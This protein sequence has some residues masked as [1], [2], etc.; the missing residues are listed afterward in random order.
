[1]VNF[2]ISID[3]NESRKLQL[4][5]YLENILKEQEDIYL[6]INSRLSAIKSF[7]E[8]K[9]NDLY[10]VAENTIEQINLISVDLINSINQT[11]LECLDSFKSRCNYDALSI[12]F[13][14]HVAKF[15][16]KW[17]DYLEKTNDDDNQLVSAN[18]LAQDLQGSLI[19]IKDNLKQDLLDDKSTGRVQEIEKLIKSKYGLDSDISFDKMKKID[20]SKHFA[21][22]FLLAFDFMHDENSIL[23]VFLTSETDQDKCI[24]FLQ[25]QKFGNLIVKN[26]T[27]RTSLT[28][29]PPHVQLITCQKRFVFTYF[30]EQYQY[31][32][33][34]N[35]EMIE[36]ASDKL[37][38]NE[39]IAKQL[40]KLRI[41]DANETKIYLLDHLDNKIKVYDWNLKVISFNNFVPDGIRSTSITQLFVRENRLFL[42]ENSHTNKI[43]ILDANEFNLIYC[44]PISTFDLSKEIFLSNCSIIVKANE[45]RKLIFYDF[46]LSY[47]YER[48]FNL[49]PSEKSDQ[50]DEG[51]FSKL[52]FRFN[53]LNE[54][55]ICLDDNKILYTLFQ[56]YNFQDF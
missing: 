48:C 5:T 35:E 53:K 26:S 3:N 9:R 46:N 24:L 41:C 15:Y 27:H 21:G 10:T 18:Q 31:I 52:L 23:F 1:L 14:D 38:R 51:L 17:I 20:L 22:R 12:Y 13:K 4:K 56:P 50:V 37:H 54:T 11:E 29:K 28:N 45:E 32:H 47:K 25:L 19:M 44:L 30:N 42:I 6:M 7:F 16:L 34:M 2:G 49:T 33:V 43:I 40:S 39:E 8:F 55:F 36:I